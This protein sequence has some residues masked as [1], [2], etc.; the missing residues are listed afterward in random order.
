MGI[1]I[2]RA[3]FVAVLAAIL[4]LLGLS[5]FG[6]FELGTSLIS[7]GQ[8]SAAA[9]SKSPLKSSFMSG[10]LATLVATPCTGPY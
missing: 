8:K 9:S 3:C 7:L 2:A 6:V 1:P 10:V 4:F 5:L